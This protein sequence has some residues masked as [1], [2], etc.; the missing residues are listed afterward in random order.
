MG[1]QL[2]PAIVELSRGHAQQLSGARLVSATAVQR[3]AQRIGRMG[4]DRDVRSDVL[5]IGRGAGWWSGQGRCRRSLLVLPRQVTVDVRC[6][7]QG[8]IGQQ[9]VRRRLV[10]ARGMQQRARRDGA[11]P[12]QIVGRGRRQQVVRRP[13]RLALRAAVGGVGLGPPPKTTSPPPALGA[14]AA[15]SSRESR[16]RIICLM[17]R[18]A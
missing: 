1:Y 11:E 3:L 18:R 2:L 10:V 4:G 5:D 6:A 7:Q 12:P 8:V 15:R 9:P 13:G 17:A 14:A 16:L